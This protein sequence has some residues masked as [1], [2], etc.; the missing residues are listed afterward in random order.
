MR[1]TQSFTQKVKDELCHNQYDSFE[2]L[3]AL[4]SAYIR[5]NGSIIFQNKQSSLLLETENAK[6]AKFVYQ[7]I[8]HLYNSDAHLSFYRNQRKR[9]TY[10][11]TIDDK[12]E[13]IITDLEI[14]F[15]EGKISK[16][17]VSNDVSIAGYLAG[18]FLAS[19]SI[20]S[21]TTSNY[22]LEISLTSENYAKWMSHLFARYKNSNIEPKITHR[23]DKY[24]LYFKKSDQIAN[25]LII[26]GAVEACMEYENIRVDR[27]F[28][29][30]ANRLTNLDTANM[31]KIYETAHRQIS[32]IKGIDSRLGIEHISNEKMR[33]LC[34]IRLEND[35]ASMQELADLLS[36]RMN[37]T[38]TKSN[39]NHLFRAIH[40]LYKRICQ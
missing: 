1:T 26:I 18:A 22:H 35:A 2:R 27:D 8:N 31:S 24:I 7:Q 13:E 25:F 6:I 40:E 23:R 34:E 9:A 19:G 30:N 3:K 11:I 4:L 15:L 17:I 14:S 12:A 21:P 28:A 33:L 16:N 37:M 36:E 38:I 5:I 39:V 20:N 32:E 10:A 29:N